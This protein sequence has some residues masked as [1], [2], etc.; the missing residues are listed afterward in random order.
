MVVGIAACLRDVDLGGT[1]QL[2]RLSR[3]G[4]Q[5]RAEAAS[6]GEGRGG[7][8]AERSSSRHD[9]R[10]GASA[11][12][13]TGAPPRRLPSGY[14]AAT[15]SGYPSLSRVGGASLSRRAV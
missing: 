13:A 1:S 11:R 12:G 7:V 5:A 2:V 6:G 10:A 14:L 3:H 8:K 15:S 4:W 9:R